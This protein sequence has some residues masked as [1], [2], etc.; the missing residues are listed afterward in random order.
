MFDLCEEGACF[1]VAIERGARLGRRL[2]WD[3]GGLLELASAA[4]ARQTRPGLA[5][6]SD[7]DQ[8]SWE[9]QSDGKIVAGGVGTERFAVSRYNADGIY[10]SRV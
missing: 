9:S 10:R 5:T 7:D 1:T 3:R 4:S 2:V 6:C 8:R